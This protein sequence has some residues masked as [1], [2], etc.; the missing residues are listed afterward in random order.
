MTTVLVSGAGV[1]GTTV[2]YWL[3]QHGYTV[4]VVERRPGLGGGGQAIQ[5]RGPALTV[6]ERMGVL[7][8]AQDLRTWVRGSALVD[9]DGNEESRDIAPQTESSDLEVP[10]GDLLELL[11]DRTRPE[12]EYL[13]GDTIT[14]IRDD[15]LGVTVTFEHEPQRDFDM[16]IG[17]D[18]LHSAVRSLVFG[19]ED[20]FIERLGTFAA[21]F[22]VPNFLD[23]DFWQTWHYGEATMAGVYSVHNNR[24]AL[25]LLG[26]SDP[27]LRV[28]PWDVEAQFAAVESRMAGE[29]WVRPQLMEYMRSAPD[30]YFDEM[31][32]IK[33]ARW[34]KGR[35]VLVGDAA[36]ACSPLSGQSPTLALVGAYILAG[37]IASARTES[38]EDYAS[39]FAAY[40]TAFGD[41]AQR[42]QWLIVDNIEGGAAIPEEVFERIVASIEPREY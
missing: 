2:A 6:L 7:A 21:A 19:P 8:E 12:V 9:A 11:Y 15:G 26:F 1:A 36:Y 3:Q 40:Q 20:E 34:S 23:L 31:A 42:N 30:F 28:D 22:T 18:G 14:G 4:T 13:F 17:A 32:Q 35:V 41:Y 16:V 38:G 27:D 37:E 5:V 39:G 24:D 25:A 33:M 29:G 10:R